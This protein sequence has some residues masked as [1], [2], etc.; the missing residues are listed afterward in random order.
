MIDAAF[1]G[2]QIIHKIGGGNTGTVYKAFDPTKNRHVALKILGN[3][4]FLSRERKARFLREARAAGMLAHPGI[5]RLYRVGERHSTPYLAMELVEGQT[6]SQIIDNHPEGIA[7]NAFYELALPVLQGMAYAHGRQ[8]A[9]R[10]IKPSNLKLSAQGQP[11]ILDF[12][13]VK[14][15]D[16]QGSPHDESFQTMAGMVLGSAGYM[17]PE[18]AEGDEFDERTDVFSLGIVMYE[19]LTGK[20]PFLGRNPFDT[21]SRVINASPLSLE[22]LRPETPMPLCNVIA[23]ALSKNMKLR[24]TNAQA[25][26]E[27]VLAAKERS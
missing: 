19:L 18:Q 27:A 24:Y 12:G 25:L 4:L 26:L 16:I 14:F 15:L 3:D 17:S 7:L 10:D 22:L 13:L 5:A 21:I 23:R 9:H 8:I 2:Y 20:N 11:K 1:S 6:F